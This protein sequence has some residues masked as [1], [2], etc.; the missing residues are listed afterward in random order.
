MLEDVE[1]GKDEP[2]I[3]LVKLELEVLDETVSNNDEELVV[4][5]ED[6]LE[7]VVL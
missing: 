7:L 3:D 4:E 2:V 6:S 5:R 1:L